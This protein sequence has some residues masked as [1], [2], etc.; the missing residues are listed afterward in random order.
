MTDI[1]TLIHQTGDGDTNAFAEVGRR[2]QDM[3]MGYGY[4]LLHDLQLAEDVAQEAF[5]DAY[6]CLPQLR[7]PAAFPGWFR[8]IV[9]KQCDRVLRKQALVVVP[10]EAEVETSARQL[11]QV[12]EL[13]QREMKD[14]VWAAIDTLPE[15]ERTP[16]LLYYMG[17]H[18]QKE[19]AAFLGVPETAIKKRLFSARQ[20]LREN[21]MDFV[22]DTLREHRPSRDTDFATSVIEM[23]KAASQGDLQKVR[24][25]LLQNKQ[26]LTA[27]DWLGNSALIVAV[28]SGHQ[29]IAELLFKSGL[30]PDVHEAAAIGQ[31][32]RV[33]KLINEDR[34][35]LDSFS[36]EGFTP[37][38]LA[39]HF[40]CRETTEC[41]IGQGADIN[42]VSRHPVQVTPLH[43]A[44]F[45][46]Q[47]ETARTLIEHGAD[48]NIKR[49]GAGWPRAGWTALHYAA[50]F[51]FTELIPL[52]LKNGADKEL[53]DDQQHTPL[54]VA[55]AEGQEEAAK[56]LR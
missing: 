38:A 12:E 7:E 55:I 20:R 24:T 3:A 39:A 4:S 29:A 37:L 49:G 26:L 22:V 15:H 18:S 11:S 45:G 43:A 56:L 36:A 31:T 34:E 8:R 5:L 35:R 25:L 21:L 42:L 51:G 33:E 44:L 41:L 32:E 2:F 53:V 52:L 46:K 17:G 19:V 10:L 40:G 48:V 54:A 14:Q 47:V 30:R 1:A 50:G 27:R 16:V 6:L 9:F 13:E 23:L 28:N